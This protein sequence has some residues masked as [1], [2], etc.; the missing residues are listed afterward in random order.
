MKKI[1]IEIASYRD[2]ELG[3]TV[4]SLL[5]QAKHP[6]RLRF[7]IAHQ[8]GPETEHTLD[9]YRDDE[10]FRLHEIPWH[11]ARGLGVARR[12]CDDMYAGEDF[13]FQIDAHMRAEREWDARLVREWEARD[14]EMAILSS[15]P[16]AYKYVA[17]AQVEF[18]PSDP[19]RLVVNAMYAGFVPT[20]FGQ[21]LRA[22]TSRRG[23]F[24]AGGFQFGPGR[25]CTEVPYEPD[26]CFVGDEI[27]HSLRVFA[28]G[29]RVYSVLDQVLW[30][31]YLR[32]EH[33]PNA[34]HFWKDFQETSEL[35]EIYEQMNARSLE[36]M[37]RYFVGQ[38]SDVRAFEEFAGV[39]LQQHTVHPDMYEL[40]NLPMGSGG[41]WRS[42]SMAP[43]TQA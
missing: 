5:R 26:V 42:R 3:K 32:S 14:D 1:L 21:A 41:E 9:K 7:A 15:Y 24:L 28:A 38:A 36:V 6:E 12:R 17:P 43:R 10:R 31:L 8:Y 11:E 37:R 20:F 27:I 19:N 16:P 23:A 39:D 4:A 29:Y 13:Y 40:P 25:V 2:D 35:A 22:D 30:H 34:R 18:V 33:Q